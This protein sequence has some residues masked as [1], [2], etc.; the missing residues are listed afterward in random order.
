MP[1]RALCSSAAA[2]R[3][4]TQPRNLAEALGLDKVDAERLMAE[5]DAHERRDSF[6]TELLREECEEDDVAM[7]WQ[8]CGGNLWERDSEL[9]WFRIEVMLT[10]FSGPTRRLEGQQ[11]PRREMDKRRAG[12]KKARTFDGPGRIP[13]ARR[14]GLPPESAPPAERRIETAIPKEARQSRRPGRSNRPRSIP[15]IRLKQACWP[16]RK[17]CPTS[18]DCS[19][20]LRAI[21][22]TA[23]LRASSPSTL[24]PRPS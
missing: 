23:S 22:R 5:Y 3:R 11:E 9:G 24:R 7:R 2:T 21:S 6:L 8:V 4:R 14:R 20:W 1:W 12:K 13:G 16:W 17:P 18:T 19:M 15:P 10:I